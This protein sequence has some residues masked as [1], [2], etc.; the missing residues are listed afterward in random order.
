MDLYIHHKNP[1][2]DYCGPAHHNTLEEARACMDTDDI[3]CEGRKTGQTRKCEHVVVINVEALS[4]LLDQVAEAN[5]KTTDEL[6]SAL[7]LECR[8]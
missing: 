1:Y 3:Y 2:D 7:E 6:W 8:G 5:G 4:F